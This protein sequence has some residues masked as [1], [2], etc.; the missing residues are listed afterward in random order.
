MM[1]VWGGQSMLPYRA[2]G[3]EAPR[4]ALGWNVCFVC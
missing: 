1:R 3:V 4:E 2:P